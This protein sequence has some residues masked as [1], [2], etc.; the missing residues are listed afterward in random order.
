MSI[1][2]VPEDSVP[3]TAAAA[4]VSESEDTFSDLED[5][6]FDIIGAEE[7]N[8]LL[9]P[10]VNIL[11]GSLGEI[12]VLPSGTTLRLEILSTWGDNYYVGLNGIDIFD[13]QGRL[14][15]YCAQGPGDKLASKKGVVYSPV[16]IRR[17]SGNPSDINVLEEYENDPRHVENLVDPCNF[18]KDDMHVWLAPRGEMVYE[19]EFD[20]STGQSDLRNNSG[21]RITYSTDATSRKHAVIAT[22]TL[23]FSEELPISMI[24]IWNYNKSRTHCLRGVRRARLLLDSKVIFDG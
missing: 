12:P 16:L 7:S 4:G 13:G 21:E 2:V 8:H 11:E 24:R 23:E 19:K 18:T 14:L 10:D 9:N 3:S 1:A 15:R 22:V 20:S 5:D 6:K 17:I